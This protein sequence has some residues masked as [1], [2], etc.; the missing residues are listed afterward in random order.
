MPSPSCLAAYISSQMVTF[1]AT[2]ASPVIPIL[3]ARRSNSAVLNLVCAF[4]LT[5]LTLE[6]DCLACDWAVPVDKEVTCE[7]STIFTRRKK[8]SSFEIV[9]TSG[10]RSDG[11]DDLGSIRPTGTSA[12]YSIECWVQSWQ[13]LLRGYIS[14][15]SKLTWKVRE[16]E[17]ESI[18]IES[19]HRYSRRH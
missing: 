5:S 9:D 12:G 14:W 18:T 19:T 10:G 4:F 15:L 2:N 16:K 17:E 11:G 8:G 3:L 1:W 7:T 13:N 6:K